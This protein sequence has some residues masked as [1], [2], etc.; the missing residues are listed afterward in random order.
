M[1]GRAVVCFMGAGTA[2]WSGAAGAVGRCKVARSGP[3]EGFQGLQP[4]RFSLA[5]LLQAGRSVISKLQ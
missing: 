4:R 3:G 2:R 5:R 1:P